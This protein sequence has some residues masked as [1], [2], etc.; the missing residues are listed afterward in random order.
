MKP[1]TTGDVIRY[2]RKRAGLSQEELGQVLGVKRVTVQKYENNSISLKTE[3]MRA[4]STLFGVSP[5]A[6]VFPETVSPDFLL[7]HK[8]D[9]LMLFYSLNDAGRA[10]AVDYV[11][12]LSGNEKYRN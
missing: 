5:W 8:K 7:D 10:K 1:M 11:L 6:F 12:D 9:N 3:N 4:L 2:L